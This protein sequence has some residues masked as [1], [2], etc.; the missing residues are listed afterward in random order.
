[1]TRR[2]PSSSHVRRYIVCTRDRGQRVVPRGRAGPDRP[3]LRVE[4][5][6]RFRVPTN[7]LTRRKSRLLAS[8]YRCTSSS[9]TSSRKKKNK[10][11]GV[12]PSLKSSAPDPGMRFDFRR[13]FL[14]EIVVDDFRS[15]AFLTLDP[16]GPKK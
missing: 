8:R 16:R 14:R 7:R 12:Y 13:K 1:M 15:L 11:T 6:V 9:P 4:R 10:R 5:F 2:R 3:R